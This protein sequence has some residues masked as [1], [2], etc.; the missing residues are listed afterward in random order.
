MARS[1][2]PRPPQRFRRRLDGRATGLPVFGAD[3]VGDYRPL[4]ENGGF[5]VESYAETTDWK[6]RAAAT[7]EAIE[8]EFRWLAAEVGQ[9]AAAASSFEMEMTLRRRVFKRRVAATAARSSP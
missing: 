5:V 7:Y 4:L 1:T 3:P 9:T 2:C 8:A 6:K